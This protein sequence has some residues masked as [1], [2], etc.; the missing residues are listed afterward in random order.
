MLKVFCDLCDKETDFRSEQEKLINSEK[1][2]Y[3]S[4]KI[5]TQK[6]VDS[7]S[8]YKN[9]AYLCKQCFINALIKFAAEL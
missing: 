7:H 9:P 6:E 2:I 3:I 1:N 4:F 8:L 5:F